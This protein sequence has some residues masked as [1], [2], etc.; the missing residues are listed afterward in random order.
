MALQQV[1][2]AE[3]LAAE[4]RLSFQFEPRLLGWRSSTTHCDA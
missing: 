3:A 2:A 4:Q 1:D